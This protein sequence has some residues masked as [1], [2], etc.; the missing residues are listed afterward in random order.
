MASRGKKPI[1]PQRLSEIARDLKRRVIE[2]ESLSKKAKRY[3][4]EGNDLTVMGE[5]MVARAQSSID[6]FI[7]SCKRELGEF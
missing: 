3:I 2:I 5:P 4:E 6:K 7:L 1:S